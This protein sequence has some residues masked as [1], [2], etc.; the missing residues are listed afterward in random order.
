MATAKAK[1]ADDAK[2]HVQEANVGGQETNAPQVPNENAEKGEKVTISASE[3]K[4]FQARL[5]QLEQQAVINQAPRN[6]SVEQ[7]LQV[8]REGPNAVTSS[9]Y[10]PAAQYGLR[11]KFQKG[12]VVEVIDKDYVA[13]V[14]KS[15]VFGPDETVLAVIDSFAARR[16]RDQAVKYRVKFG[17][18]E[19]REDVL[20]EDEVTLYQR[21]SDDR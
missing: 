6:V 4:K 11:L 17:K 19:M 8:A 3:W 16:S 13:R 20:Y 14:R 15:G 9:T 5:G 2:G 21:S 7:L 10:D 12:Q 18:R 1:E